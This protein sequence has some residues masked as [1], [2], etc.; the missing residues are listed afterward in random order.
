MKSLKLEV[1]QADKVIGRGEYIRMDQDE[2]TL[3]LHASIANLYLYDPDKLSPG[4]LFTLRVH[5][6]DHTQCDDV[7]LILLDH[8]KHGAT[9]TLLAK[10]DHSCP[11][12]WFDYSA[13]LFDIFHNWN[14]GVDLDWRSLTSEVEKKAWIRACNRKNGIMTDFQAGNSFEIDCNR[15]WSELDFYCLI[16]EV[17]FGRTGY[18]GGEDNA[19]LDCLNALVRGKL[20]HGSKIIVR[21][22]N[23]LKSNVSPEFENHLKSFLLPDFEKRGFKVCYLETAK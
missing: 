17:F 2:N 21:D 8:Q 22:L 1:L 20:D 14:N 3:V 12:N 5:L 23:T 13:S 7:N 6:I 4:D 11:T 18:L 15:I 19:F 16:G 10:L 9:D